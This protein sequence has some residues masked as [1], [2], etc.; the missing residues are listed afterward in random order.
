MVTL[1]CK[2][3]DESRKAEPSSE[4]L[5]IEREKACIDHRVDARR[6]H[7]MLWRDTTLKSSPK[8]AQN[9]GYC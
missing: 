2:T 4:R 1:T 6:A 5:G 9:G 7:E 3:L 8:K